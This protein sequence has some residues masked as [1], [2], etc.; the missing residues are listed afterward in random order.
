MQ[1]QIHMYTFKMYLHKD[2][3]ICVC[4]QYFFILKTLFLNM[5]GNNPEI[6]LFLFASRS[7]YV[8]QADLNIVALL[9]KNHF[10]STFKKI[11]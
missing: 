1:Q 4:V 7:S 2:A 9:Y 3:N 11:L 5:N 10:P 6:H 8:A